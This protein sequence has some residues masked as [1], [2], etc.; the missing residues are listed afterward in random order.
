MSII[1]NSLKEKHIKDIN[2]IHDRGGNIPEEMRAVLVDKIWRICREELKNA[3]IR[4]I[5]SNIKYKIQE[6]FWQIS[7]ASE[8]GVE[9]YEKEY[10]NE[11]A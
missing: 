2:Y 4:K 7:H 5:W 6:S 1:I 9:S 10:N 11:H 8:N 3:V